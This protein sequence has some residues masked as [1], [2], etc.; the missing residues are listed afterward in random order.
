MGFRLLPRNDD[1][2]ADFDEAVGLVC[3][4]TRIMKEAVAQPVLPK[5]LA[6]T[7]KALEVKGDVVTKRCLVRLD[8]SFVTPIEREDIHSLAVTIDDVADALEAATNR[9]DIFGVTEPTEALRA[10]VGALDEI[11]QQL[12]PVVSG[13][14]TLQPAKVRD[15][16]WKVSELEEKVDVLVREALREL[17]QRR[18]E[19]YE[20]LRWR[21]IYG[22]LE[23]ASDYG[24]NVAR[25]VGHILVRHS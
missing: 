5:D 14:R 8:T 25:M 18:P 15:A 19:A 4:M 21:E 10:I 7:I 6:A 22:I 1:Y 16:A 13:V 11:A 20:L 23:Q 9:F 12:V 17:F 2:F 24:R 3:E